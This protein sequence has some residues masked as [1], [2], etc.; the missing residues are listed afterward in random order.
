M[1]SISIEILQENDLF[2][3]HLGNSQWLRFENITKA[4]AF[5]RKYKKV[6]RD[7]VGIL[8][9]LQPQLNALYR[10]NIMSLDPV[11]Q[12]KASEELKTFDNRFEYVFQKYSAGNQNAF[13]FLNIT[14]CFVCLYD[15]TN[16][17]YDYSKRY[18]QYGLKQSLL[19]ILKNLDLLDKQMEI[20]RRNLFIQYDYSKKVKIINLL[21]KSI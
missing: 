18:K 21:E 13:V 4:E 8:N 20:D 1:K 19:P 9:F 2:L 17:L 15:L 3:I 11:T 16:I 10:Q 14:T 12:R 7:N 6:I 5:V